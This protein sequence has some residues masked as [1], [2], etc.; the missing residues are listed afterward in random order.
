MALG[1]ELLTKGGHGI[2]SV[3]LLD[4]TDYNR[5]NIK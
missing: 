4:K 3:A 5:E 1:R 2:A